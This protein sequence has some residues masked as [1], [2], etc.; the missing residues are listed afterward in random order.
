MLWSTNSSDLYVIEKY[1]RNSKTW[2]MRRFY[3]LKKNCYGASQNHFNKEHR[4]KLVYFVPERI[5]AVIKSSRWNN[6]VLFFFI[7]NQFYTSFLKIELFQN[8][9]L[10][11]NSKKIIE[12]SQNVHLFNILKKVLRLICY[13][14][15]YG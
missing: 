15:I 10:Y 5:K 6:F 7:I 9:F 8:I 14:F 12:I 11:M 3:Q 1:V 4:F 2:S 13:Y